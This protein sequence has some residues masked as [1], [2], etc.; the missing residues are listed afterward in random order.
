MNTTSPRKPRV[1][2]LGGGFAGIYTGMEL[3]RAQKGRDDFEIVLVNSENY[4]VFQPML[5]E[6]ISG[7]IGL[8]DVVSPLRRCCR[9]RSSTCAKWS[10]WTSTARWW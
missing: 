3:E 6:V 1:L 10:R 4:F 7:S 5:P 9:A 8:T 2:I